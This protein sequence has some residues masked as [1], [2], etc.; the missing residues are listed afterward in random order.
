[1]D[2]GRAQGLALLF[3]GQRIVPDP[4]AIENDIFDLSIDT[5]YTAAITDQPSPEERGPFAGC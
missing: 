3:A 1:M 5:S 4:R 2:D